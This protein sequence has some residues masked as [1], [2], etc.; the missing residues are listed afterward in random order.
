MSNQ[1]F[2]LKIDSVKGESQDKEFKDYIQVD[3]WGW[4]ISQPVHI[5]EG[6]GGGAGKASASDLYIVHRIDSA[7]ATLMGL[8]T[9]GK[10]IGNAELVCRKAGGDGVA[11][12]KLTMTEVIISH[13]SQQGGGSDFPTE[14]F[15]LAFASIKQE[16]TPQT[17]KGAKGATITAEYDFKKNAEK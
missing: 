13:V 3:G 14:S 6:S 2:F 7:S 9:K 15:N 16:Y 8:C 5:H 4:S 1:D 11:Y 12:L 10:P 17:D